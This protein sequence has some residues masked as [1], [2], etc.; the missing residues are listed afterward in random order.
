MEFPFL[1]SICLDYKTKKRRKAKEELI[2]FKNTHEA[3]I[4]E[5][6]WNNAQRLRKTVRR[7]PKDRKIYRY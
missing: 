3:I 1:L 2:I 6:T 7:S 5:E 4:D